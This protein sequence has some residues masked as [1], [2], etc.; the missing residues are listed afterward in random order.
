[1]TKVGT[2]SDTILISLNDACAMTSLSRT[3]LNRL[4]TEGTFPAEVRLTPQ[5]FAFVKSEV[6][7]WVRDR[8]ARRDEAA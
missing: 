1:M 5:R 6:E 3:S 8:I 4:R 2:L 7:G